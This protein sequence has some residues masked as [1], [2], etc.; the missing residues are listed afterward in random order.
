MCI[1]N[2]LWFIC[3]GCNQKTNIVKL[4]HAAD[5][6][7]S[8]STLQTDEDHLNALLAINQCRVDWSILGAN[9]AHTMCPPNLG[10]IFSTQPCRNIMNHYDH[11]GP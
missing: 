7:T 2:A 11:Y 9:E 10:L 4:L 1:G 5:F 8:Q 6:S 3:P